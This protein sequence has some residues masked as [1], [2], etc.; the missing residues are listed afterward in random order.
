MNKKFLTEQIK[1]KEVFEKAYMY[2]IYYRV[3]HDSF[4][5]FIEIDYYRQNKEI[6]LQEIELALLTPNLYE[7]ETAFS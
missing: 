1:K 3:K 5:N 6:L 7:P 4:C 2:A